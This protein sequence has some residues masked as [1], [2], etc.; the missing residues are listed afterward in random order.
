MADEKRLIEGRPIAAGVLLKIDLDRPALLDAALQQRRLVAERPAFDGE[1]LMVGEMA[2]R[3]TGL[4]L[5]AK[6]DFEVLHL[7][8]E[9]LLDRGGTLMVAATASLI[10]LVAGSG[11]GD[12]D[13]NLAQQFAFCHAVDVGR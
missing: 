4:D 12:D 7:V 10:W 11:R 2:Q 6:F 3:L 8:S 9:R 5:L 13:C 1:R